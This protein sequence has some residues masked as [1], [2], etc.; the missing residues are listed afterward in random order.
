TGGVEVRNSIEATPITKVLPASAAPMSTP[1]S[2]RDRTLTR[3]K[4]NPKAMNGTWAIANH[5]G[6]T[7]PT[8]NATITSTTH[9]RAGRTGSQINS[10]DTDRTN[11]LM[12]LIEGFQ[13]VSTPGSTSVDG[14]SMV[15]AVI[16]ALPATR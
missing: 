1:S 9:N 15:K 3:N 13:R 14:C 7:L 10:S 11:R 6:G 2:E 12:S 5:L 16:P 4:P 8:V